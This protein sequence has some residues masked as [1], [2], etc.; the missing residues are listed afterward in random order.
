MIQGGAD[1]EQCAVVRLVPVVAHQGVA[2]AHRLEDAVQLFVRQV[3]QR[4]L[5][6][7]QMADHAL[8]C[9]RPL[10][11]QRIR[12]LAGNVQDGAPDIV[13]LGRCPVP[14]G[15]GGIGI[16]QAHHAQGGAACLQLAGNVLRQNAAGGP[17][18]QMAGPGGLQ[19]LDQV[20]I[21]GRQGAQRGVAAVL[22]G[23]GR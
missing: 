12:I 17:A 18:Q 20:R 22:P 14:P 4:V 10:P 3:A 9:Q 15:I 6:R 5:L 11:G 16:Q 8:P 23:Q 21:M 19:L 13:G 2:E 1:V 7:T